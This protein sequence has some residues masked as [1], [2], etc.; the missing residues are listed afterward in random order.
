MLN[1]I[2]LALLII[3]V[4]FL[5]YI[6]YKLTFSKPGGSSEV[7]DEKTITMLQNQLSDLNQQLN[8]R[9]DKSN[10]TINIPYAYADLRFNPE[11]DKKT[12]FFS[13]LQKIRQTYP[14]SSTRCSY[15]R[16]WG[17]TELSNW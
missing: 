8:S 7:T 13:K 6:A 16:H 17:I 14:H 3:V 12:G 15:N 9:L 10:E 2:L 4:C 11:F 5:I 1:Y